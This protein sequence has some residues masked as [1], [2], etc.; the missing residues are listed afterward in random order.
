M[1]DSPCA[2]PI[3]EIV[4]LFALP[5]IVLF[6][7]AV[8]PLHIFE[9]R[10]RKMTAD[11]LQTHQQIAMA[12]L[13]PGW[14]KDYYGHPAIDP[15]VCV[16][17]ILSHEQLSDGRYN[18]LLQ[19]K[20]RARI[21]TEVPGEPYRQVRLEVLKEEQAEESE[22]EEA[23]KTLIK[24]FERSAYAAMAGGEQVRALLA[25]EVPMA[26]VADLLA[27]RLV[28]DDRI[29]FKQSLLAKANV[30]TRVW[31][32]VEAIAGLKPQWQNVPQ[33]AELN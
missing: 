25:S 33:D 31:Q 30:K 11:V 14:E 29:E 9:D 28:P 8:M 26:T 1:D 3:P 4:P 16:G 10:Y 19:G 21:I 27:F 22:L 24:L 17:T 13:K 6:P 20:L 5:N 32:I 23:R 18:F 12:L 15:V 2:I 7:C